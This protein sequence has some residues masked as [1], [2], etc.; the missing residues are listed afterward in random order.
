MTTTWYTSDPHWGHNWVA[1][2]R[3]FAN[4]QE[5]D[6]QL[7]ENFQQTI[8]KRDTVFWM[9]DL[10]MNSP[11]FAIAYTQAIPGTHHLI[12]GNHDKAH[13]MNSDARRWQKKYFEAFD[14]VQV[15]GRAKIHGSNFLM[16]HHPYEGEGDRDMA[17]RQVQWRLRDE[18][19]TLI[20]GHIHAPW[21]ESKTEAGTLQIHVGLD[22]WNMQPVP[23]DT[24]YD[25]AA[26][27]DNGRLEGDE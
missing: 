2:L 15:Y 6:A 1:G 8:G 19:V 21:Q 13:P 23:G 25:M 27:Q 24:I 18:G 26:G 17:D 12:L 7:L 11:E 10:A 4:T 16:A 3:G 20:H 5:H 14:S 9:G 22:A